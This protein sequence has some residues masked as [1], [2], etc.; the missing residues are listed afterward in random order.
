MTGQ[1]RLIVSIL[2]VI[3]S[4]LTPAVKNAPSD[5]DSVRG[6][7]TMNDGISLSSDDLTSTHIQYIFLHF[8]RETSC[9]SV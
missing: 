1:N 5:K 7:N 9:L 3:L 6:E 2:H 8:L 4:V